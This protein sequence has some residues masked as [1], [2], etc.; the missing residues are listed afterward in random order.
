MTEI[1]PK[2]GDGAYS[3]EQWLRLGEIYGFTSISR[4]LSHDLKIPQH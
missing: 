2:G 3:G 1:N 4:G